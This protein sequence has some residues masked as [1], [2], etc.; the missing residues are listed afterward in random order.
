MTDAGQEFAENTNYLPSSARARLRLGERFSRNPR[1][2]RS[3]ELCSG[4]GFRD[5]SGLCIQR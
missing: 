3:F 2:F 4:N 5:N 1:G